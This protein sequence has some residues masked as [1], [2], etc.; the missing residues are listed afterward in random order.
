[1]L[2]FGG[3]GGQEIRGFNPGP[4]TCLTERCRL[5]EICCVQ[6]AESVAAAGELRQPAH[7]RDAGTV[8]APADVAIGRLTRVPEDRRVKGEAVQEPEHPDLFFRIQLLELLEGV[9]ECL[10]FRGPARFR[11]GQGVIDVVRRNPRCPHHGLSGRRKD[12]A[13]HSGVDATLSHGF[14]RKRQAREMGIAGRVRCAEVDERAIQ[15]RLEVREGAGI[16][17]RFRLIGSHGS[18]E[19]SPGRLSIERRLQPERL[20]GLRVPGQAQDPR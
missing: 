16:R 8:F 15:P 11:D 20:G 4:P 1:M 18:S 19:A 14:E 12:H 13:M 3:R 17:G 7:E 10:P 6:C 9:A 5:F 2:E